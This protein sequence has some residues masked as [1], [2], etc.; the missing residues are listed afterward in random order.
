MMDD[1]SIIMCY[2]YKVTNLNMVA[3]VWD[4]SF[5]SSTNAER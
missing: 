5:D 4:Q 1:L 2:M 3:I